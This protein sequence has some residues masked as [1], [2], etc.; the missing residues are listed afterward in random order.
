[1]FRPLVATITSGA[2][3]GCG[4]SWPNKAAALSRPEVHQIQT[5]DVLPIDLEVWTENGYPITP[6]EIRDAASNDLMVTALDAVQKRSYVIDGLIDWNGAIDGRGEVMPP[7]DVDATIATLARYDTVAGQ[8]ALHLPDPHLPAKLGGVSGADATL[9]LGGWAYVAAQHESTGEK[10]AEGVLIGVAV[11]AVVAIVAIALSGSK[12][13]GGSSHGGGGGG[14]HGGGGG[15]H[16]APAFH[17]HRTVATTDSPQFATIVVH[18]HRST[19]GAGSIIRDHRGSE[20]SGGVRVSESHPVRIDT[21]I[22]I[23]D[24]LDPQRSVHPDWSGDVPE[25]GDAQMYVEM[26]LVDNAT[27]AV[28]WHAHQK[29]PANAASKQDVARVARTMLASLP[30]H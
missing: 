4:A 6:E 27:G 30:G 3:I 10:I 2:L 8:Y 15:G 18:D 29:F 5:I 28:V 7:A 26:T 21:A 9:Y 13:H 19:E 14:S 1:M 20:P 22:D 24:S 16:A 12:S 23:V 25:G 17:D 11:I